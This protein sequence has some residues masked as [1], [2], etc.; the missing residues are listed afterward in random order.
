MA[1]GNTA[2]YTYLQTKTGV[3]NLISTRM[4]PD[5]LPQ[6]HTL[7]CIVYRVISKNPEHDFGG[8]SPLTRYR[9]QLDSYATTRLGADALALAVWNAMDGYRG[10]MGTENAQTCHMDNE[11]S[12]VDAAIDATDVARYITMQDWLIA[13]TDTAPTL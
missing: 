1:D 2:L 4:Y 8:T 12:D 6:G 5:E 3:T 13:F 9:F 7:P 10:T 11:R